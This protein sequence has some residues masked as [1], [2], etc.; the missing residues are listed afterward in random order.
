MP[1]TF[2]KA[3][4]LFLVLATPVAADP[5]VG[6]GLTFTYG[7]GQ[8]DTG[9]GVRLFSDN[10]RKDVVGS[11]GVDYMMKSRTIR[12]NIGVAYLASKSYVGLDLGYD[13]T[14]GDITVGIGLGAA[15]SKKK[16][17]AAPA[18]IVPGPVLTATTR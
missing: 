11:L 14:G 2:L 9:I 12:P 10:E 5:A 6:L 18:P 13:F 8:S 4:P 3:L 15:N 7:A 17:A 1:N 16:A